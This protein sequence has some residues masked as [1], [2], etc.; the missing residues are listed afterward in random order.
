MARALARRRTRLLGG[1]ALASLIA[2]SGWAQSGAQV[3]G[4]GGGVPDLAPGDGV[5]RG[6]IVLPE[7]VRTGADLEIILYA[8]QANGQPGLR[9]GQA[10][11]SGFFS[12][13]AMA[14]AARAQE[15]A[16]FTASEIARA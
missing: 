7:G 16:E 8:L 10:D 6:R 2:T 3:T 4:P 15:V 1:L 9:R 14:V 5:V 12:A 13:S 11:P